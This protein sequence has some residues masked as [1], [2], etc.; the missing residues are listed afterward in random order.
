MAVQRLV[1]VPTLISKAYQGKKALSYELM[2]L[3]FQCKQTENYSF[4]DNC[5]AGNILCLV[6]RGLYFDFRS[7]K[8]KKFFPSSMGEVSLSSKVLH[9][10]SLNSTDLM[11]I[12]YQQCWP[13]YCKRNALLTWCRL[14]LVRSK[15]HDRLAFCS[16]G[17]F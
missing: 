13:Y 10:I 15:N 1:A 7:A 3:L 8:P 12:Q 11:I 16:H 14:Q 2:S 5:A 4:C 6:S 9:W 17:T